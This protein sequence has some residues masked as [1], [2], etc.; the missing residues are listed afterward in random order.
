L[1]VVNEI[2]TRC[3]TI[4]VVEPVREKRGII[5]GIHIG[6]ES[7]SHLAFSEHAGETRYDHFDCALDRVS[8]Y[9]GG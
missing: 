4:H 8:F 5:L 1:V 2:P 7:S 3:V 6:I 9:F